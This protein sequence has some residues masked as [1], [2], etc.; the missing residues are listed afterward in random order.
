MIFGRVR[1]TLRET[2][3]IATAVIWQIIQLQ[4]FKEQ[5]A[6]IPL[7]PRIGQRSRRIRLST[8]PRNGLFRER[9]E[10]LRLVEGDDACV[11]RVV[12]V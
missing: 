10:V 5:R 6:H 3:H 1:M 8:S 4:T 11:A 2:V 9:L 12:Y 7:S